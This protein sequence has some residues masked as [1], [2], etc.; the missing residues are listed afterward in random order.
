[1]KKTAIALLFTFI[2]AS[3]GFTQVLKTKGVENTLWTGMGVPTGTP[4]SSER[5]SFRWYGFIDTIQVRADISKFTID[6]MLAWGALTSWD[7]NEISDFTFVNT[8]AKPIDF[9]HQDDANGRRSSA[10]NK[11]DDSHGNDSYYLT[12]I[13]HPLK[14]LDFGMGT[15]LEWSVG[16]NPTYGGN[17]WE[18]TSHVHQ[19]DLREGIPGSVPVAGFVK[20]SNTY[21]QKAL[22][23]RY[24][25]NDLFQVGA[26]I[27][28]GFTT[29]A[30]A[31][32][33][34]AEVTPLD[35]L[36]VA[37]A[38]EGLFVGDGNLYAGATIRFT[39]D[40]ILD[41]YI[42][43]NNMGDNYGSNGRW[44]TG[45]GLLINF[46]SVGLSLRPE[47]GFTWYGNSDY[48]MATY[49]GA[50]LNF[51]FNGKCHLGCWASLAWGA[52]NSQWHNSNNFD[53][54]KTKDYTGGF[55]FNIRP[56][57][58][59]DLDSNN[60][61]AVTTEFQALTNFKN[62]Q[63]DSTLIGIYWRYKN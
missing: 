18:F 48:T 26:S 13:F 6:G 17:T 38:Y 51:D 61:L 59:Y 20:Y 63:I 27:P 54:P 3:A 42:A 53:Y 32:N 9:M 31:V 34:A 1:M 58:S 39:R 25:H 5:D 24:K 37:F 11:G 2:I 47:V 56:E 14:G 15:R 62:E 44:G 16:P 28:S 4:N 52:E 60:T 57:F 35:L 36:S 23:V 12:F 49:T 43:F 29:H 21:A 8:A 22:A 30:P 55:I 10:Y 33:I 46:S 7:H 50:K 41:G 19:G 40:C 45:A